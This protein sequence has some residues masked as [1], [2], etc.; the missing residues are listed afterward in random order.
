[1][2]TVRRVRPP[3]CPYPAPPY[4]RRAFTATF[5]LLVPAFIG[6]RAGLPVWWMLGPIIGM[7]FLAGIAD[8]LWEFRTGNWR[9]WTRIA[10]RR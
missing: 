3:G 6:L 1:M 2:L 5:L 10:F 9:N 7:W 8:L 4:G